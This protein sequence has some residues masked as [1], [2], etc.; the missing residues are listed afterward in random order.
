VSFDTVWSLLTV[1]VTND[2]D[3]LSLASAAD[4][5]I[6]TIKEVQETTDKLPSP[7][8]ITKAMVPEV[9]V[10]KWRIC[11]NS[12][13]DEATS[14]VGVH[15][16]QERDKQVVRVPKCLERLLADPVMGCGVDHKH[17]KQHDVASDTT[18]FCVVNLKSNLRS[19][20]SAFNVEEAIVVRTFHTCHNSS[21]YLT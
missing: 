20:L 18:S 3:N 7:A 14:S 12:V 8:F 6:E 17:A 1:W 9:I 15:A 10:V 13:T 21:T 5:A 19:D 11:R 2:L 4:L 16:E